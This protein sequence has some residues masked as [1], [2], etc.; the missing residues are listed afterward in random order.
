MT[1]PLDFI[2]DF[3]RIMRDTSKEYFNFKFQTKLGTFPADV[4]NTAVDSTF[5]N[6][7]LSILNPSPFSP[8]K[9]LSTTGFVSGTFSNPSYSF[10]NGLG[11]SMQFIIDSITSEYEFYSYMIGVDTI[12]YSFL[13]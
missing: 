2:E 7:V 1:S 11:F 8:I 12:V 13:P 9:G 5:R 10:Q 6:D 4:R 3:S